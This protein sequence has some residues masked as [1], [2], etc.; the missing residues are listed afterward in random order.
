MTTLVSSKAVRSTGSPNVFETTFTPGSLGSDGALFIG[1]AAVDLVDIAAVKWD[2]TLC[3]YV[4]AQ[5]G[6]EVWQIVAPTEGTNLL[7]RVE[8]GSGV[9]KNIFVAVSSWSG[10]DQTTPSGTLVGVSGSSTGART[11]P[12]SGSITCPSGGAIIGWFY[13]EY[14]DADATASAGTLIGQNRTSGGVIAHAYRT[15]N[16]VLTFSDSN[17]AVNWRAAALPINAATG[18][19][20]SETIAHGTFTLTGQTV[21]YKLS[22]E[23]ATSTIVFSGQDVSFTYQQPGVYTVELEPGILTFSSPESYSGIGTLLETALLS[24]TG[25]NVNFRWSG[26]PVVTARQTSIS[27]ANKIGL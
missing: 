9:F 17:Y 3:S 6:L 5:A 14:S 22:S 19:S 24:F 8:L 1:V 12:S 18:G 21:S 16:G 23:L 26:D 20:T 10:V 4:G 27:I 25:K 11:V 15:T 13:D 7:V 2:G